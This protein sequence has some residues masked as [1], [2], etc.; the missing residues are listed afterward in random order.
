MIGQI[1]RFNENQDFILIDA[2]PR[3]AKI[4]KVTLMLSQLCLVPL[5]ASA[6]EIWATTDLLK[7]INATKAHRPAIDVRI[8]WN[9]FRLP[10]NQQQSYQ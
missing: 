6:A 1:K 4:T 10:Q 3:I 7:I 9:R 2:P 5:R 8:I